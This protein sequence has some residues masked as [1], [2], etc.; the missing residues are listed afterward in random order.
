[1]GEEVN[2]ASRLE[3]GS[4]RYG[5]YFHTTY[6]TL[7]VAGVNRYEWRYIDRIIFKG[8][9]KHKQT[10]EI[11]GYKGEVHQDTLKLIELFHQGLDFYYQKD[12]DQAIKIFE[13]CLKYETIDHQSDLNPST[14]FLDRCK[15]YK[16]EAP[17]PNWNGIIR[18]KEK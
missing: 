6:K 3:S 4:K 15:K 7:K 5:I 8:F 13:N 14:I 11:L 1:M 10:I 16:V 2:L 12:W 18:L 17:N 9:T